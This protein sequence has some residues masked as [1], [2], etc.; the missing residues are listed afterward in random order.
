M[1][2]TDYHTHSMM[3]PD[4]STPLEDQAEAAVRAGL[5]E[6]CITDHYDILSLHGGRMPP[7]DWAPALEQYQRVQAQ[8]QG[9]L[10]LKLGIEL[11]CG[12]L[13]DSVL[14]AAPAALDFVIGS[15]HNR[16]EAVGG[17]DFYYGAYTSPANCFEA[18]DN[19]VASLELL[20]A[21]DAYDVLGHII[22]P[23]RY[24]ERDG[25]QISM[26]PYTDRVRAL[27]TRAIEA[28]R[29]M[30]INTYNGRTLADWKPWL[31]LY[32]QLG[33]EI[34]TVGSDAHVSENIGKGIPD[35]YELAR[36]AGFRYL[37]VYQGRKPQFIKL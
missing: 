22:Y 15:V 11:G 36:E 28:G 3:S 20:A 6:L 5:S 10:T 1:Y 14:R 16:S 8:Y 21:T 7:Y 13:D 30:E 25:Q 34:L 32:R 2:Y 35:A 37:T 17:E 29:G 9:R 12:H 31:A 24:M 4:S 18:L 19:Y 23:L 26:E 27:L 33:G